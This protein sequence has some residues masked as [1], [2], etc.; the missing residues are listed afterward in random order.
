V[1]GE[2]A[3]KFAVGKKKK[4]K[5]KRTGICLAPRRFTC[6]REGRQKENSRTDRISGFFVVGGTRKNKLRLS[7]PD[8]KPCM[9]NN[10]PAGGLSKTNRNWVLMSH[11]IAPRSYRRTTSGRGEGRQ[12]GQRVGLTI[13]GD[14]RGCVYRRIWGL[15]WPNREFASE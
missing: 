2:T 8:G 13:A 14:C 5:K 12:E 11:E 9:I 1:Q 4:K 10:G 15:S 7:L 3:V 6:C